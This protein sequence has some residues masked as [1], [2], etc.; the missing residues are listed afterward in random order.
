MPPA[1]TP[2]VKRVLSLVAQTA[3]GLIAVAIATILIG[4]RIMG[5]DVVTVLSGSMDP[6]YPIDSVLAIESVDPAKIEEGDVIAFKPEDDRP[7]VTHRVIAVEKTPIGPRFT[8]KGDANEDP[9]RT[10]VAAK[11]VHGRVVF[12]VPLLGK[13]IRAAHNPLGFLLLLVLPAFAVIGHESRSIVRTLREDRKARRDEAI[14][15]DVAGD[16]PP[17]LAPVGSAPV[18]LAPLAVEPTEPSAVLD[19]A[20]PARQLVIVTVAA[21]WAN[22]REIVDLAS[23]SGGTLVAVGRS[24]VAFALAAEPSTVAA[25]ERLL[26]P[27]GILSTQRSGVLSV[28]L[29]ADGAGSPH[30]VT[31]EFDRIVADA[32][33]EPASLAPGGDGS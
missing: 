23:L 25:F 32:L 1:S 11:A 24:A 6:T 5:W 4:P 19:P 17:T 20:A 2:K 9:D 26:Q 12:G 3:V 28:V 30:H 18:A 31:T 16:G 27:F 10:P 22:R 15:P 8:T 33:D 29:P 7:M 14:D 13:L 21:S